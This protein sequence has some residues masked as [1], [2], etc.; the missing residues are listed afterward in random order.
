MFI[1]ESFPCKCMDQAQDQDV[2]EIQNDLDFL[3]QE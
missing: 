2:Y 1:I 3:P